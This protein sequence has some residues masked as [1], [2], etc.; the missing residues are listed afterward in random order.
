[1]KILRSSRRK[2]CAGVAAVEFALVLPLLVMLALPVVD[3]ARAI[4][5]NLI[6]INMSR[7]GASL[8]SRSALPPGES[9]PYQQ[10]MSSLAATAP[11]LDMGTNG[12][13]YV[14]KIM[15]HLDKGVVQNVVIE[16]YRWA[17]GWHE[18]AYAPASNVWTCGSGG[19]TWVNNGTS[20]GSCSGIP[21][22][23]ST[24][25]PP[26]IA[27]VMTGQLNDGDVIYAVESF[28]RFNMLFGGLNVGFGKI[29]VIGPNLEA[30]TVF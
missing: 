2:A 26:V 3:F 20:D 25:P 4:D 13:I 22:A 23:G 21:G 14:T 10:I 29:P 17:Q 30:M 12:M 16:Q 19:T 28:Y 6:L 18:S 15:G 9:Q 27:N 11:P 24:S 5:A 8:T 7:E 1:M